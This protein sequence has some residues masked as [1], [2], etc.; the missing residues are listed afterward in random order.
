VEKLYKYY[1]DIRSKTPS[2]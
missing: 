2:I 1:C